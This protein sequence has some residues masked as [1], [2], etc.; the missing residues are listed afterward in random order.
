MRNKLAA[1]LISARRSGVT[2]G[3]EFMGGLILLA[4]N[5]VAD[6]YVEEKKLDQFFIDME[7]EL[8]R[9]Y[10]Q[11]MDSVPSGEIDEMAEKIVY[12]VGE[13]RKKRGMDNGEKES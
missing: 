2:N 8:Q 1:Q 4:L 6:D 9:L 5:N 7:N 3:I 10:Q 11:T 13:I 12:H